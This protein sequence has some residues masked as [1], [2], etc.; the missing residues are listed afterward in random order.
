MNDNVLADKMQHF[1]RHRDGASFE[2]VFSP[3]KPLKFVYPVNPVRLNQ[4]LIIQQG[5]FL[6]PADVKVSF[7]ENLAATAT[8]FGGLEI[9]KFVFGRIGYSR[10][11]D[12]VASHEHDSGNVVSW[13][14]WVFAKLPLAP[15]VHLRRQPI[16]RDRDLIRRTM[17]PN[18]AMEPSA[19]SC[20]SGAAA[21]C[22]R[23]A[24]STEEPT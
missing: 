11:D 2:A 17:L 24:S 13:V 12:G 9:Y 5:V 6:C 8:V 22:G 4:R 19:P 10:G 15:P 21:H 7:E 18:S 3:D 20:R 14:G 23:W 16:P 1:R